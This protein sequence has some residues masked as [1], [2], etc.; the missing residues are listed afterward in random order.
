MTY[1][2]AAVALRPK[3]PERERE[4]V[5]VCMCDET[6]IESNVLQRSRR[7]GRFVRL[8]RGGA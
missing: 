2:G 7:S 3:M 6:T 1:L 4:S 5:C 8:V